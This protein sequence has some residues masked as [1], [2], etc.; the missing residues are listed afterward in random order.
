VGK[1][2]ISCRKNDVG[3]RRTLNTKQQMSTVIDDDEW[4]DVPDFEGLYK[5]NRKGEIWSVKR[6]IIKK[7]QLGGGTYYRIQLRK[8]DKVHTLRV[9]LIVATAFLE[10]P[11]D[12]SMVI[13]HKDGNKTNNHVDNLHWT[14]QRNNMSLAIERGELK[15]RTRA[16]R[17]MKDGVVVAEYP[18][19]KEAAAQ[20]GIN[21]SHLCNVL[22]KQQGHVTAGGFEWEYVDGDT[23]VEVKDVE[24]VP[25]RGDDNYKVTPDGQIYSR[26]TKRFLRQRVDEGYYLVDINL[27]TGL[28]KNVRVGRLVAEHFLPNPDNLPVVRYKNGN[29][30]DN[31][32]ENLEWTTYAVSAQS[33]HAANPYAYGK[34]VAQIDLETN[35][36][37][38]VFKNQKEAYD[39]FGKTQNG[40]I[41]KV[42][43][44]QLP[45]AFG[46]GWEWAGDGD[47]SE[48]NST[49]SDI[50]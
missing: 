12:S 23:K 46:F 6:N 36:I 16:V 8:G 1:I 45:S 40:R 11:A 20:L 38:K 15:H 31:R 2:C 27:R 47:S 39:E 33:H 37:I 44:G 25:V 17:Q 14:T 32:A 34:S 35:Q 9:H 4:R 5:V 29:K 19:I 3:K 41:R 50:K 43:K 48:D 24:G 22:R 21:R 7:P 42:C 18:S 13:D 49:G 10:P 30:L 26:K 28:A